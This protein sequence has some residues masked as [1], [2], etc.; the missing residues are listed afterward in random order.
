[1]VRLIASISFFLLSTVFFFFLTLLSYDCSRYRSSIGGERGHLEGS[2]RSS[3][4]RNPKVEEKE[5]EGG[6]VIC[7]CAS[8]KFHAR[9]DEQKISFEKIN[10]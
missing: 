6:K 8:V 9:S 7:F 3:N 2:I 10:I 5:E 4:G 1:M